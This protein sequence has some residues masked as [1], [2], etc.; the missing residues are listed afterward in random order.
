MGKLSRLMKKRVSDPNAI[1]STWPTAA[2]DVAKGRNASVK[3]EAIGKDLF[4]IV[5]T[6]RLEIGIMCTLSYNYYGL[7]LASL[8][9]LDLANVSCWR[10]Q[11]ITRKSAYSL[12]YFTHLILPNICLGRTFGYEDKVC[13]RAWERIVNGDIP[14]RNAR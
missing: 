11:T 8:A 1:P 10:D 4:D 6:N 9:V 12:D 5:R 7:T 14:S 2:L 3:T 13:A